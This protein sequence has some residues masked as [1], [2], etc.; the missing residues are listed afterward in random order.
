MSQWVLDVWNFFS[1][2]S[3]DDGFRNRLRPT[4]LPGWAYSRA[5]ALYLDEEAKGRVRLFS[6]AL[7]YNAYKHRFS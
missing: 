1:K 2:V 6:C 5:L 3:D 4:V 7:R